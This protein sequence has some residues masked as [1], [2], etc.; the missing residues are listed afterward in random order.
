MH[1]KNKLIFNTDDIKILVLNKINNLTRNINE[2]S[3][4]EIKNELDGVKNLILKY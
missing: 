1:T 4:M 3:K 2:N